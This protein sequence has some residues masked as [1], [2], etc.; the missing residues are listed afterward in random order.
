[1]KPYVPDAWIDWENIAIGCE[2]SFNKYFYKPVALRTL[3]ENEADIIAL[4]KESDGF[5][6]ELLSTAGK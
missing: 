6:K 3:Q 4:D 2:I 1:V 5:I